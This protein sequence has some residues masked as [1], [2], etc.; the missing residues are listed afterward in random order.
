MVAKKDHGKKCG[1]CGG[2]GHN[3]RTCTKV[4]EATESVA[5]PAPVAVAVETP[6][7]KPAKTPKA[8]RPTR[9]EEDDLAI[10]DGEGDEEGDN[11]IDVPVGLVLAPPQRK[12]SR[13]KAED[14]F[15][16]ATEKKLAPD[17][18][19][20]A[21]ELALE[22]PRISSGNFAIDA[23]LFGGIPQGRFVRAIGLPKCSK[24]GFC[25]NTVATYQMEHC[26][27][28]FQRDCDCKNR[29]VPDVLWI[30]A[31]NRMSAM[32]GWVKGHGINL[33]C[34]RVLAPPSGQNVVDLVDHVIRESPVSKI[35]L[36]VVDSLAHIVSQDVISKATLDGTTVGRNASLLN[37]AWQKWT[38]AL[39][40]LG[41]KNNRKPTVLA[42][43][44]IRYKVGQNYGSPETTPGGVGQDF[45]STVDLRFSAG[46][47]T[48]VVKDKTGAWVAK[49]KGYKSTFKPPKDST[50]DFIQ[51]S[52]RVTASGHCPP[53]RFGEFNYWMKS[54]HG[55][56]CGD[57]DNG[58]QLWNYA[59][60]YGLV[61][62]EGKTK[63]ILGLSA[64]TYDALQEI[65]RND[66]EAKKKAWSILMEK[67]CR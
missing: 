52:F 39:H 2:A 47:P 35:G 48:Y 12:R 24:T 46:P 60:R 3:A 31:E 16:S 17:A 13:T 56:R 1:A 8:P 55:H 25:L 54:A 36:I 27:E 53:G 19:A 9:G 6:S 41:I 40:S 38:S 66:A 22:I 62:E 63:S 29:D 30:D 64:P 45:A 10:E 26:S 59:K 44:Q 11:A 65:F 37:T 32:M 58:L 61:T 51:V 50:P 14:A 57:P 20:P 4:G 34:F 43:N 5:A 49:Q 18:L 21:G 23:A 67:L 42:I 15:W 33:D 28:C 7:P